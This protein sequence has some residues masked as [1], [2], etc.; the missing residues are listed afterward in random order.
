MF[1]MTL[2]FFKSY[3]S[4][5]K[6]RDDSTHFDFDCFGSNQS[7]FDINHFNNMSEKQCS[8]L[9]G[10]SMLL[11]SKLSMLDNANVGQ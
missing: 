11:S 5:C 2:A 10:H 8:N 6:Y 3:G 7:I 4:L 1:W 9:T